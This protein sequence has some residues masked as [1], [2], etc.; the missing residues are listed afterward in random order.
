MLVKPALDC[1]REKFP[2]L[3]QF[4]SFLMFPYLDLPLYF[5]KVKYYFT[6]LPYG[7]IMTVKFVYSCSSRLYASHAPPNRP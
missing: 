1:I 2:C 4:R 6:F 7:R 5:E 3:T